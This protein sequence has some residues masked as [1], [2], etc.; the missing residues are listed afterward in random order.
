MAPSSGLAIQVIR[1][2]VFLAT[3]LEAF[4]GRG[5]GDY[6]FSHDLGDVVSVVDGRDSLAVECREAPAELRDYLGER[7]RAL[8]SSRALMDALPGHLPA[9]AASQE[10]LPELEAQLRALARLRGA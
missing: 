8:L 7:F 10:R 6:L 9:D 3:K 1:A 5:Q 2:P 4:A